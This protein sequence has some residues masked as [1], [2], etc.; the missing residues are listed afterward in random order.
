MKSGIGRSSNRSNKPG[1]IMG[2]LIGLAIVAGVAATQG[3][4]A[5]Q[6]SGIIIYGNDIDL[7]GNLKYNV[8]SVTI[9]DT[10]DASP[11]VGTITP[12][13]SFV[14]LTCADTGQQPGCIMGLSETG[15]VDGQRLTVVLVSTTFSV[16]WPDEP[17][18][19]LGKN[20]QMNL[21]G[22]TVE[23]I[24]SSTVSAWLMTSVSLNQKGIFSQ[25]NADGN[26]Q[27]ANAAWGSLNSIDFEG[28]TAD[29][30][31]FRLLAGDPE[32]D[33]NIVL[34]QAG[35]SGSGILL[36][37]DTL[38]G[39][40]PSADDGTMLWCSTCDPVSVPCT[41]AGAASGNFAFRENGAWNCK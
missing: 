9:A 40:L 2:L 29:G 4:L 27:A 35:S 34:F 30:F 20:P 13:S 7:R 6:G 32:K 36:D 1:F 26:P 17:G 3:T 38:F 23:F 39:D 22:E 8:Q 31:E 21:V 33:V 25:A 28:E 5:T 37:S 41:G 24:Y 18:V 19:M 12:T 15:A 11:A 10:G 14:A 16:T